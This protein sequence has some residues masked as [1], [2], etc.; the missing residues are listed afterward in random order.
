MEPGAETYYEINS[1]IE[2][3]GSEE[4]DEEFSDGGFAGRESDTEEWSEDN[5]EDS[6]I[7]F[8]CVMADDGVV[9]SEI[10]SLKMMCLIVLQNEKKLKENEKML[11]IL[12]DIKTPFI[13]LL[14][15]HVL[16]ISRSIPDGL[17][18]IHSGF[19][20]MFHSGKP[21]NIIEQPFNVEFAVEKLSVLH[22][23][24]I[25]NLCVRNVRSSYYLHK[26]TEVNYFII[27]VSKYI[28]G[29]DGYVCA[30]LYNGDQKHSLLLHAFD[31]E[32]NEPVDTTEDKFKDALEIFADPKLVPLE[33]FCLFD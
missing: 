32:S 2:S 24:M 33:E 4:H 26:L 1:N 31:Y 20:N 11:S 13:E 16:A 27:S 12:M 3:N 10:A 19:A 6:G 30:Y 25:R 29:H 21:R 22:I 9:C 7:E 17:F 28:G 23:S 14:D 5:G 8:R 15:Q 18:D